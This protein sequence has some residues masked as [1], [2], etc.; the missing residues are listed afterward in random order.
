[1]SLNT[2][3]IPVNFK[4]SVKINSQFHIWRE[5]DINILKRNHVIYVK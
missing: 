2:Y 4:N 1:M 5:T 3:N